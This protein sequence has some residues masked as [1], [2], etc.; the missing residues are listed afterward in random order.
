MKGKDEMIFCHLKAYFIK[1]SGV[2][3]YPHLWVFCEIT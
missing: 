2:G 3:L 1:L